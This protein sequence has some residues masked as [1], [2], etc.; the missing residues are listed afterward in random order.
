MMGGEGVIHDWRRR[1]DTLWE[2]QEGYM[3]GGEGV[4]HDWRRRRDT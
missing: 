3:M 4:I 2:V 1:R